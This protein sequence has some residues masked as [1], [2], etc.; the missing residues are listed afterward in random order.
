MLRSPERAALRT[1]LTGPV[2]AVGYAYDE[3][4]LVEDMIASVPEAVFSTLTWD[5][6]SE[7]AEHARITVA[8]DCEVFFCDPHSP[9]Q[10]PTNENTNGLVREYYPKGTRFDSSVSDSDVQAMQDQLNR[11][12]RKVLEYATPAEVLG[13]MLLAGVP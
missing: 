9:W 10:R 1:I 5:Q 11:R 2:K 8:T 13:D 6:G 4:D 12:P 3:P 7:M